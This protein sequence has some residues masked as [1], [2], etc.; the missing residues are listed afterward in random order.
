MKVEIHETLVFLCVCVCVY[1]RV[2]AWCSYDRSVFTVEGC[3]CGKGGGTFGWTVLEGRS[4]GQNTVGESGVYI[5][6]ADL[7]DDFYHTALS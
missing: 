1:R 6:S 3:A 2:L 7:R 5:A 4:F